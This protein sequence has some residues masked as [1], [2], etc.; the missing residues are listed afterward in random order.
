MKYLL[1]PVHLIQFWY[2][3]GLVFFLRIWKHAM[4]YLEE[5]LAVGLMVKLFFTPLFHDSSFVGRILSFLFRL[6]RIIMGLFAFTLF[7]MLILA[8]A[9]YWFMLPLLSFYDQPYIISQVLL[10]TGIGI[11]LVHVFTHPHSKVW[12]IKKDSDL[13]DASTVSKNDL[14]F[15]Y[16]LKNQRI[17]D[18]LANLEIQLD[19]TPNW[20]ITDKEKVAG[21]AFELAKLTQSYYIE[22]NHFFVAAIEQ[23][24]EID[25]FLLKFELTLDDFEKA[26]IYQEKKRDTFRHVHLW[27]D[28]F[29]V[30]H[31][32]GTNRGWLGVPT[33]DLNKVGEDITKKASEEKRA[34]F[35]RNNGVMSEIVNVLS[36][37]TGTNVVLVGSAGSGKSALVYNL[38]KQIVTGDAPS[39]LATK[40][41]IMLD[42]AKLLSGIKTQGD[43]AERIKN[44]F[45]EVSYAGNIIIVV[46]EIHQLGL[47]EAGGEFN[48]YSLMQPYLEADTG[49]FQFIGTTEPENYSRIV[50]KNSTFA[51]LFRKVEMPSATVE[52]TMMILQSRAIN[53]EKKYRI[54]ITYLALKVA[55]SLSKKLVHDKVLPDSAISVFKEAQTTVN[56]G[57]WMT[58]DT[59]KK[60]LSLRVKIPLADIG[61]ADKGKLL[62]LET[63]IHSKMIDQEPAVKAVSDALRRAATGLKD[64]K[65]PIGSFLFVG[66]TGVGKTEL[67]KILSQVYFKTE[68]AFVRFDM[69][70]YQNPDSVNKLIGATGDGGY[71]TE[72]VRHKPYCLL[73]LDEFE[74]AD[75]RVLTL[76]LQVLEDGRLTDGAGRTV[77]F[78]NTIIIATSNAASIAIA[79][80]LQSGKTI[81]EIDSKVKDELLQ[82]FKPELVNRF[83]DIV[84]FKPLS[85]QDLQKIVQLKLTSLEKQMREKGYIIEFDKALV[86]ECARRGFDPVLGARPLRR[87]I[88]DTLESK[89]S[90]MILEGK[91]VKGQIFKA[92]VE[93]LS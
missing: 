60:V 35:V 12:Q 72:E 51:R 10:F 16:L 50:E 76:F 71:L 61:T 53:T 3:E 90:T 91:L 19:H 78:T 15:G 58:T 89:L 42:L 65:R 85:E 37:S 30:H 74:K 43:L 11:F 70:E 4:L 75:A 41:I 67:A 40:R 32:K 55:V 13:W 57:A 8:I 47:G 54:R 83:D 87:L 77:D 17:M 14:S 9:L 22:P 26:L 34:D 46:D 1:L 63:E 84:I 82:V 69:S 38:A 79:Q 31:L 81:E 29:I 92:G 66:P 80:D 68:G 39:S 56:K 2:E 52:D 27:D 36:Q 93:L 33:P 88:Q 45:D 28:D 86:S 6:I 21:R 48:L 5:D 7:S 18:F 44:I 62:N 23:I 64:E 20:E 73:L 59:I 49:S 25:K 24:P